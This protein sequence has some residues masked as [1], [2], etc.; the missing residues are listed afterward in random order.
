MRHG[1]NGGDDNTTIKFDWKEDNKDEWDDCNV[2]GDNRHGGDAIDNAIIC[3]LK[4]G[5]VND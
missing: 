4:R 3:H 1:G 2:R 5:G